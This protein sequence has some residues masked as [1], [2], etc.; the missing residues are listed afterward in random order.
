MLGLPKST[1]LSKTIFKKNLHQKFGLS[2]KEKRSL[3]EDI[4][5]MT[6]VHEVSPASSNVA[7]GADIA[8]FFVVQVQLKKEDFS[9]NNIIH[10]A[11]FIPHK[12]LFVLEY[13]GK[14]MLAVYETKLLKTK[15]SSTDDLTVPFEGMN[16]DDVWSKIVSVVLGGEWNNELSIGENID[17]QAELE[18]IKKEIAQLERQIKNEKQPK[19]K[20]ELVKKMKKLKE[21]LI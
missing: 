1:E 4:A 8:R 19:K 3:D 12:T 6:I 13:E 20:F 2:E 17:N 15:W 11:K 7:A 18:R 5:K 16:L 10:L 9:D 14:A 21:K